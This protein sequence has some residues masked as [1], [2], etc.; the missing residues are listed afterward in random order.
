MKIPAKN[1]KGIVY[2]Q[3]SELPV[4]QQELILQTIRK[5][6]FIKLLIGD[7]VIGSCLQYKDYEVWYHN[8]YKINV[9]GNAVPKP[10]V[11]QEEILIS[12]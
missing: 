12:K 3:L 2:V 5:D 6:L 9:S 4:E 11:I 7:K 1:F 8:I 10:V